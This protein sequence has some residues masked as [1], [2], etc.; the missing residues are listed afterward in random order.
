MKT[1][2]QFIYIVKFG[3]VNIFN[4]IQLTFK[5]NLHTKKII[6]TKERKNLN[7][8]NTHILFRNIFLWILVCVFLTND[9]NSVPKFCAHKQTI[10]F[11]DKITP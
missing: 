6:K 3:N 9:S 7:D 2:Y 5:E 10:Y 11:T 1:P 4:N 8:I